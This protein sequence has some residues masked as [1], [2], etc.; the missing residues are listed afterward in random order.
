MILAEVK[1]LIVIEKEK[2]NI[3]KWEIRID[4]NLSLKTLNMQINFCL[5]SIYHTSLS[6]MDCRLAMYESAAR[7]QTQQFFFFVSLMIWK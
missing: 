1:T 7:F 6:Q 2:N 4:R 3:P 5:Q